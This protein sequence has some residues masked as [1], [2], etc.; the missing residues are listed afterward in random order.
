M[1]K[2]VTFFLNLSFCYLFRYGRYMYNSVAFFLSPSF[3]IIERKFLLLVG[4][5]NI[6]FSEYKLLPSIHSETGVIW[7]SKEALFL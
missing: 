6:P 4:K 5:K 2:L 7:Y 3:Y 1:I